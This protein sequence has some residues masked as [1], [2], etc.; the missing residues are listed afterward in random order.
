MS[1]PEATSDL[2]VRYPITAAHVR[3][4]E[5]TTVVSIRSPDPQ[6]IILWLAR[7]IRDLGYEVLLDHDYGVDAA[8][9]PEP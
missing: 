4:E 9:G 8:T 3:K 5:T 6:L 2:T 7:V 1:R